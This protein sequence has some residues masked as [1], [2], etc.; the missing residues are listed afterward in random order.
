MQDVLESFSFARGLGHRP[1]A[2]AARRSRHG[3]LRASACMMYGQNGN[4]L[5]AVQAQF[6]FGDGT[7]AYLRRQHAKLRGAA[8]AVNP[9][10]VRSGLEQR[11][12]RNILSHLLSVGVVPLAIWRGGC[13]HAVQRLSRQ[14]ALAG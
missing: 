9:L 8:A 3:G 14:W 1:K 10:A 7:R 2:F 4:K 12:G 13:C 11:T 5:F 6:R